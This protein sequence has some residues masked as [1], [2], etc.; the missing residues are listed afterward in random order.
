MSEVSWWETGHNH[1]KNDCGVIGGSFRLHSELKA[2]T[3][4]GDIQRL[5]RMR[6]G[7]RVLC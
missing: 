6:A 3:L 5:C 7:N 1:R 2:I 4:S